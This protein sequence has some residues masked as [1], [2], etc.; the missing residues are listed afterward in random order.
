[1]DS[2]EMYNCS[3]ID[4]QKAALRF[5][6]AITHPHEVKNCAFHNGLGWGMLALRSKNIIFDNNVWFNFRVVGVGMNDVRDVVFSNNF[7]S[8][9]R[10]NPTLD[11]GPG[12]IDGQGGVLICSLGSG[13]CP[14]VKVV[15][16][17]VAGAIYAGM[18]M[19]GHDCGTVNPQVFRDNVVHSI[20][21][22]K[23]G[24]GAMIYPDPSSKN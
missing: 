3:Q 1:M 21:G 2:V 22:G 19:Y 14:N 6:N 9:V 18:T 11:T 10:H 8:H 17:I 23:N 4:T 24:V 12:T 7:V 20:N 5:E 15:K 13:P 16:N